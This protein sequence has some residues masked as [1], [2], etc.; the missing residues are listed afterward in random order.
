MNKVEFN[1]FRGDFSNISPKIGHN[2]QKLVIGIKDEGYF[3]KL[4]CGRNNI[5]RI[6]FSTMESK[7]HA[8][9]ERLFPEFYF[10][11]GKDN[12]LS[13]VELRTLQSKLIK[14]KILSK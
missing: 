8:K 7:Y 5:G 9:E 4:E 13:G 1:K 3:Y 14:D 12:Y 6:V 2:D 10:Q 11:I